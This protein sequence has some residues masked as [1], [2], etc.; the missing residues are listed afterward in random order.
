MHLQTCFVPML[1]FVWLIGRSR[2]LIPLLLAGAHRQGLMAERTYEHQQHPAAF[3]HSVI[4]NNTTERRAQDSTYFSL[5]K[6]EIG[7]NQKNIFFSLKA[8]LW[9]LFTLF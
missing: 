8:I 6:P 2:R 9:D 7:R 5:S 3:M 4:W 1:A